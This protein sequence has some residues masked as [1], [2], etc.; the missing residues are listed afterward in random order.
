MHLLCDRTERLFTRGQ[1]ALAARDFDAA[2]AALRQALATDPDYP[3]IHLHLAM[4]E[5]ERGRLDEAEAHLRRAIA[6]DPRN[7]VFPLE[8]GVRR[9]DAGDLPAARRHLAEAAHLAPDNPLVAAYRLLASDQLPAPDPAA[10]RPLRGLPAAFRA[11]LLVRLLGAVLERHGPEAA[12]Q[13]PFED[14]PGP[15]GDAPGLLERWQRRR[16]LARARRALARG[17]PD[18]AAA[19]LAAVSWTPEAGEVAELAARAAAALREQG[20]SGGDRRLAWLDLA[21]VHL[22]TGRS[23]AAYDALER[24]L[25]EPDASRGV[26]AR[27]RHGMAWIEAARGE[28]A[29]AVRSCEAAREAGA[30]REVDWIEAVAR[31]GLGDRQRARW[32]LEDYLAPEIRPIDLAAA[33][34]LRLLAVV[35]AAVSLFTG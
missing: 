5:A 11:R 35:V 17:R 15:A 9:L 13:D 19:A 26:T 21:Q 34:L 1:R 10:L 30:G 2:V 28:F 6:L 16:A 31:L 7:F 29:R 3:Q 20:S 24:G 14:E 4:A 12:L 32:R 33:R 23:E 27:A 25:A 18:R 8:M 22:D